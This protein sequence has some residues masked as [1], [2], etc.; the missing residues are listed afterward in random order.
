MNNLAD[1]HETAMPKLQPEDKKF[2]SVPV[3]NKGINNEDD[4]RAYKG[5]LA[6]VPDDFLL[7][8]LQSRAANPNSRQNVPA[9]VSDAVLSVFP[10]LNDAEIKAK[11]GGLASRVR[12]GLN[13]NPEAGGQNAQRLQDD[14]L[15]IRALKENGI[16]FVQMPV[17]DGITSPQYF[18]LL[19]ENPQKWGRG[20]F[21]KFSDQTWDSAEHNG[22]AGSQ[23]AEIVGNILAKQ[24]GFSN[25]SPRIA[26]GDDAGPYLL[27]DIFLNNADGRIIGGY[28]PSRVT[29]PESRLLNGVLNGVMGVLDRHPGNGDLFDGNGAIPIDFGRAEF[30]RR[31]A[32]Q[33]LDYFVSL[34][35]QDKKPWNGYKN[36]LN[37]LRGQ[38]RIRETE[39]IREDLKELMATAQKKIR[40]SFKQLDEVDRIY[41]AVNDTTKTLRRENLEYNLNQLSK[42]AFIEGLMDRILRP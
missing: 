1:N 11:L 15:L 10:Q 5:S 40:D 31:S 29:D 18:F 42:T 12:K 26:G 8:A 24:L 7:A 37:G 19:D 22:N 39:A 25:G 17:G 38:D 14:I 6:D 27:M 13:K 20:Y 9:E 3:G 35:R 28:D 2:I 32:T 23:H 36:R 21:L 34:H 4:A 33:L 30:E 16:D 41:D